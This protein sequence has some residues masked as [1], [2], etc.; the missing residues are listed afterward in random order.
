MSSKSYS[1]ITMHNKTISKFNCSKD[2]LPKL[3]K[4]FIEEETELLTIA[5][6]PEKKK[7]KI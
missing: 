2:Y 7:E 6:M 1:I 5:K 3:I 4:D